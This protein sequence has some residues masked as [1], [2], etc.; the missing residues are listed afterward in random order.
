MESTDKAHPMEIWSCNDSL[1]NSLVFEFCLAAIV[2]LGG[3]K[4]A[5]WWNRYGYQTSIHVCGTFSANKHCESSINSTLWLYH[6]A[7][8]FEAESCCNRTCLQEGKSCFKVD[9]SFRGLSGVVLLCLGRCVWQE[10]HS[11]R[12]YGVLSNWP[13]AKEVPIFILAV[14]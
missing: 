4:G 12:L 11:S 8:G 9:F 1:K 7:L 2:S 3:V 10:A 14:F 5:K 13:L 6:R